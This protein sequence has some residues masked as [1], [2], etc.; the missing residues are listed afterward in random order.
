MKNLR[1]YFLIAVLVSL[2]VLANVAHATG[3]KVK[4]PAA[5]AYSQVAWYQP[6][7]DFFNF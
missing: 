1:K 7:L 2:P 6:V 4:P 5:Q 3:A